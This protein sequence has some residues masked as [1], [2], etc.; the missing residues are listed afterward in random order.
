MANQKRLGTK[1][2]AGP[3]KKKFK[4]FPGAAVAIGSAIMYDVPGRG[5][6]KGT[7]TGR[8]KSKGWYY[9]EFAFDPRSKRIVNID[10]DGRNRVWRYA[11]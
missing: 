8:H 6:Q 11:N 10:E 1:N 4:T 3:A 5:F 2:N 9:A 7:V